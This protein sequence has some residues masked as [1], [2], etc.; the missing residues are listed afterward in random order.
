MNENN[1]IQLFEDKRIRTVWSEEE[2]EWYFSIVDV[3]GILTDNDYQGGRKYWK[4]LKGRLKDEGS[5]LVT[6]CYQLKMTAPDGKK[7]LTDVASTQRLLCIIQFVTKIAQTKPY[8]AV[9]CDSSF[10]SDST[11]VNFEQMF[12]TYS[13]TTIRKVL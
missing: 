12:K 1:N 2:Q 5:E 4:V 7:R 13:P 9:F 11:L 8:Y 10:A 6:N 3:I